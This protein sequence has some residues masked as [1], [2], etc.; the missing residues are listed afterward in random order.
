MVSMVSA[1]DLESTN[2]QDKRIEE[3]FNALD[4]EQ[5]GYLDLKDLRAGLKKIDHPLKNAGELVNDVLRN[6]DTNNDGRISYLEFHTF[7]KHT[8]EELRTMFRVIDHNE[9]GKLDRNEL[10]KAFH[11]AGLTVSNRKLDQFFEQ[12]DTNHDGHVS[13][14][15]WRDFLLFLPSSP[16][17]ESVLS[18][19]TTTVRLSSEGDVVIS[20]DTIQGLGYFAAGGLAGV[21]SRTATAPLDRLKV[22]LIAQTSKPQNALPSIKNMSA[23]AVTNTFT[24]TI[25]DA[26]RELWAAGGMRS[27]YAGNGLNVIKVMPESAIRFGIFEATKR[28]GAQLEGHNDPSK[29]A[30][31]TT[32][33]AGGFAGMASQFAVY[34]LDTLKFR[35]QCETVS[36]GLHGNKLIIA[37]AQK[38]WT[39]NG[40]KPFYKGVTAGLLGIFPYSAIDLGTFDYL[41]KRIT[42]YNIE[43]RGLH[44]DDAPPT[45]AITA[46][47]GGFSGALGASIVYP[48]N[49]LRTRL[50]SQGTVLHPPTY[51]GFVD[52]TMKTIKGEGFKGLFK[53][54]IPNLVK[55][56]PSVSITYV[57]YEHC[58]KSWG[59]N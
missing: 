58:K 5:K 53:G 44:E 38:M 42:K 49:V 22:Y 27:L 39:K 24:R 30:Q 1:L 20:D 16:N 23:V 41:K 2:S 18:Y 59:L 7:V 46:A 14:Q 34:P 26:V 15:E 28:V 57:V 52:V 21:I 55:V 31:H 37:T 4:V 32:T 17:L 50:Q 47:I 35:M 48:I 36:G 43:T 6:I 10:K 3:L 9:D 45:G 54:L 19:Y 40:I 33:I 8:E 51:D 29:I 12:V 25:S 13:F 11:Q 56:V